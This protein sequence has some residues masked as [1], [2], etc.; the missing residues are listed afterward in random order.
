MNITKEFSLQYQKV[1]IEE[2]NVEEFEVEDVLS[3]LNR[4]GIEEA[5]KMAKLVLESPYH[6]KNMRGG[7]G[8]PQQYSKPKTQTAP[9]K[10]SS[11]GNAKNSYGMPYGTDG[12]WN[13]LINKM[14]L[15]KEKFS[16]DENEGY[17]QVQ[18]AFKDKNS[19]Y[20]YK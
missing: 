6:E 7:G 4:M 5:E 13:A 12:Q 17:Q 19:H 14:G 8:K 10:Q 16:K 2:T 18:E 20:K 11:G 1:V 15:N 9:P 3:K